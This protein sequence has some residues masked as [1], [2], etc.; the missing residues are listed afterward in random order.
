MTREEWSGFRRGFAVGAFVGAMGVAIALSL[1]GNFNSKVAHGESVLPI[2][3]SD[4][5]N[6]DTVASSS[7]NPKIRVFLR[8]VPSR[9]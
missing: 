8:D 5:L 1:N 7:Y 2:T 6:S 4:A 3:Y 9:G